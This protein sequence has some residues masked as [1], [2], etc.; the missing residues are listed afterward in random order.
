MVNH[1]PSR[2]LNFKALR[3]SADF[4]KVLASYGI[5]LVKDG[6]RPGQFKALCPFH[7][8]QE[9]SLKVNTDK[10]IYH[11]FACEAKGN[12]LEFVMAM[13]DITIRD[14]AKKVAEISGQPVDRAT[15]SPP[16]EPET[17]APV[18]NDLPTK[19]PPLS[20]A[21]KLEQDAELTD[22][23]ASRGIDAA[24]TERFGLGRVSAR[25]K[26]IAGRL[27][28]PLHNQVG[29]LIG[30]C[31]RHVGDDPPADVPKY[32]M[33]KQ[34]RKEI[35]LFNL[36]RYNA[37]PPPLR[38][39]FAVLVE[40]FLSVIR[41]STHLNPLSTMGRT[42]SPEQIALLQQAGIKRVIIAFDGD[43]PGRAGASEVAGKL[44]PHLWV[45]V[46]NLPDGVKPHQLSWSEFRT[47]LVDAWKG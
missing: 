26:T 19:N 37:H 21:L 36:H 27:A 2:R 6:S 7:D 15:P 47:L 13:D 8:D 33:P 17:P 44:A 40:S 25:S 39:R 28:I 34:F 30:Y 24:A 1:M 46:L 32:I 11:C 20:F 31:G 14:A 45:R 38:F 9:P 29:E 23:L 42:I 22:W 18:V 5:T 10:N 35:E 16:A 3:A 12:V 43:D 4:P 41:H